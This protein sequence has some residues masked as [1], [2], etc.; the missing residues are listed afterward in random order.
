MFAPAIGWKLQY[1]EVDIELPVSTATAEAPPYVAAIDEIIDYPVREATATVYPPTIA[2]GVLPA[3]S[4][5]M[6]AGTQVFQAGYWAGVAGSLDAEPLAGES[7]VLQ[8]T[9]SAGITAN[10]WMSN[11]VL[12]FLSGKQFYLDGVKLSGNS[13]WSYSADNNRTS[14]T[15]TSFTGGTVPTYTNGVQYFIELKP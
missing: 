10:I 7:I 9:S 8:I 11:N 14:L 4:F 5:T 15:W 2:A 6:T 12:P 1:P 13:S 3:Y